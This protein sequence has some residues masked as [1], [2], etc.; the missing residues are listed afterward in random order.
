MSIYSRFTEYISTFIDDNI[1][2]WN[3]K[4]DDRFIYMLE[5]VKPKCAHLCFVEMKKT[6]FLI[7]Y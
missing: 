6:Q 5:H 3:F 4:S 1:N 7:I 2:T